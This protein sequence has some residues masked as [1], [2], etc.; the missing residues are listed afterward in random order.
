MDKV[1]RIVSLSG[2]RKRKLATVTF[3]LGLFLAGSLFTGNLR[4]AR[5]DTVYSVNTIVNP[6][7]ESMPLLSGWV[8]DVFDDGN[9]GSTITANSSLAHSG[10][11]SAR[12]D[13]SNNA[14]EF[15][16]P[17]VKNIVLA[18]ISL[19]QY[20]PPNTLF[21]NV[22]DRS[23]G[24]N[25][26]FY[27]Q[28][29]FAGWPI[30]EMRIRAG[31]TAEMDYVYYSP[32]LAN[33]FSFPNSTTG[34]EGGKPLKEFLLPSPTLNQWV[35]FSR[36]VKEDWLAPLKL[37]N[38]MSAPGF[39]LNDTIYRFEVNAYFYRDSI[40]NSIYA[41]TAWVDD[42]AIYLGSLMPLPN[43]SFQ[44]KSGNSVDGSISRMIV[45]ARGV[46]VSLTPGTIIPSGSYTLLAYY[47]GYLILTDPIT[48]GTPSSIR[49]QMVAIGTSLS[50]YLVFNSTVT[51]ATV[52]ENSSSRIVFSVVGT[53]PSLI[54]MKV[55]VKP[56]TVEKDGNAISSWTFN[57]TTSTV[58]I[59]TAQLGTFTLIY[60]NQAPPT[61]LRYY[62]VGLIGGTLVLISSVLLW[63]RKAHSSKSGE[64]R[65]NGKAVSMKQFKPKNKRPQSRS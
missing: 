39:P 62:I 29:K 34:S 45:D 38:G 1:V 65:R 17:Y 8:P 9:A 61:S 41:E 25:L 58:A 40:T 2:S 6:G 60:S 64:A 32:S 59:Q 12:L 37:S 47:Q 55:P 27:L 26:W 16:P 19:V 35:H 43:F 20:L 14:T 33:T 54:I 11:Y 3:I 57:S 42:V 5:A 10:S 13:V 18:H 15:K 23:D 48:P 50:T 31:S 63:R 28:P 7:F 52:V 30:F 44:D 24:L 22:T 49:L 51:S 4:Q 53:G 36:N 21:N 56:L 46:Q